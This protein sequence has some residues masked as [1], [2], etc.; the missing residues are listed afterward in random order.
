MSQDPTKAKLANIKRGAY[1]FGIVGRLST[2]YGVLF[3]LAFISSCLAGEA[4]IFKYGVHSL[5]NSI[6]PLIYGWLFLLGRD[7][8]EA[9]ESLIKEIGEIV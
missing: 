2:A 5:A 3:L 4:A 6:M 9:I 8:L 1:Y 7:A